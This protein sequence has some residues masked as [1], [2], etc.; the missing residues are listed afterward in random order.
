MINP[1]KTGDI[2]FVKHKLAGLTLG[3]LLALV[4]LFGSYCGG[5]PA[6]SHSDNASVNAS[7]TIDGATEYQTIDGFGGTEHWLF[8]PSFEYSRIFD[9]LGVSIVRFRMVQYVE[10]T[11]GQPGNEAEND[12]GDPFVID[13]NGVKTQYFGDPIAPFLKAA[14]SRG[15]KIFGN[16]MSAP[17]WMKTNNAND[18]NG[19]LKPGYEDELVEF[20]LIWIKGMERYHGVHIDYVNFSNEPNYARSYDGILLTESQIADLTKRLGA[21]LA[22]ENIN[23]KIVPMEVSNLFSFPGW[24]NAICKDPIARSYI[25]RLTTHSYNIDFF[26]PDQNNNN[27]ISAYN[28]AQSYGKPLW[29]TEYCLD[30]D[31]YKGTWREAIALVQHVHNALCYGNVSAWL[32]H[33]MYR[34]PS[35]TPLALIDGDPSVPGSSIVYPK[36]YALKQYFRYVRPGAV[37]IK[38]ESDNGDILVTSFIHKP[39]KMFTLVAINRQSHDQIVDFNLRNIQG[40]SSLD[41]VRTSEHENTVSVGRIPGISSSFT[42]TLPAESVTTF[43]G[44]ISTAGTIY[45]PYVVVGRGYSTS[46]TII[47]TS[48]SAF[49]G[50]LVLKGQAGDSFSVTFSGDC[51]ATGFSCPISIAPG[52]TISVVANAPG[53]DD[54]MRAGWGKVESPR[55]S[56]SGVSTVQIKENGA[57]K[58]IAGILASQPTNVTAVPVDDDGVSRFTGFALSNPGYEDI[59]IA[60][61]PITSDGIVL[62]A[63]YPRELNPLSPQKQ[64][65]RYLTESAYIVP[66]FKGS[67]VLVASGSGQFLALAL[68]QNEEHFSAIPLI[69]TR[70]PNLL[71]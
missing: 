55:S 8:P 68:A 3:I 70:R 49:N 61:V 28:T 35:L 51:D 9:E 58:S 45:F 41:T 37:R 54:L 29:L 26:A 22:A 60:L 7:V 20:I 38:G 6:A 31:G 47:N 4:L 12:N 36:F 27:W 53:A 24:A 32:Y 13:W 30:S 11:P 17:P 1:Q 43:T 64:V 25:D 39:N 10:S 57:L 16:I 48:A 69:P 46:F 50:N 15:A 67:V 2:F 21:R 59:N 23:T 34:D 56:L 42:S 14:Q 40:L 66:P 63:I 33:E 62:S 18:G 19:S 5:H 65:S 52:G 71:H 44:T